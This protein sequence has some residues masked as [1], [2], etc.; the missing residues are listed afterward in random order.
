[1]KKID[2]EYDMPPQPSHYFGDAV[3]AH[4][5]RVE[6][7]RRRDFQSKVASCVIDRYTEEL[8]YHWKDKEEEEDKASQKDG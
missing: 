2:L 7:D 8:K 4:E 3:E 1:M 6:V 5:Y